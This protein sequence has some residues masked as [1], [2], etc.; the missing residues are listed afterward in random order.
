MENGT[1]NKFIKNNKDVSRIGLVGCRIITIVQRLTQ[2]L[3]QLVGA[4]AGLAYM[5]KLHVVHGDLKGVRNHS[6]KLSAR[7]CDDDH[8]EMSS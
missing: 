2:H 6:V 8:R 7:Q 3:A 4:M 5:H 1:I